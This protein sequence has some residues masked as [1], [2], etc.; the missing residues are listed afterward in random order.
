MARFITDDFIADLP[1][2]PSEAWAKAALLGYEYVKGGVSEDLSS[3]DDI[4]RR[5]EVLDFLVELSN[6]L[7]V[8]TSL[9]LRQTTKSQHER[10]LSAY[11]EALRIKQ[12]GKV[13]KISE[14]YK[15]SGGNELVSPMSP[16]T[17]MD[18][19]RHARDLKE[20]VSG[21]EI[22]KK[23]KSRLLARLEKFEQDL[24][25]G[26]TTLRE[27]ALVVT[28]I[29]GALATTT[30]TL[31]TAPAAWETLGRISGLIGYE[32]EQEEEL[33]LLTKQNDLIAIP[34]PSKASEGK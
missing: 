15:V 3:D 10:L 6:K 33:K 27:A 16:K 19:I 20:A 34:A 21:S 7:N 25:T 4:I 28:M 30:G 29:G 13:L 12:Q 9:T 31:A 26:R 22:D 18:I 1:E 24:L 2:S 8:S 17:K 32:I 14:K 23:H 11:S 5:Q